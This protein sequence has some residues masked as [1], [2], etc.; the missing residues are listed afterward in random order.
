[1]RYYWFQRNPVGLT[2]V[3]SAGASGEKLAMYRIYAARPDH[4]LRTANYISLEVT[5]LGQY[6]TGCPIPTDPSSLFLLLFCRQIVKPL[7]CESACC[8]NRIC[9]TNPN[10]QSCTVWQQGAGK[11][12]KVC[13]GKYCYMLN[14]SSSDSRQEACDIIN[15]KNNATE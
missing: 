2:K 4:R 5:K 12:K 10:P 6:R 3:A 11:G 8:R 7:A 14:S 9:C 13:M 15:S 1:M